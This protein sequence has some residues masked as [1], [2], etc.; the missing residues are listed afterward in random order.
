MQDIQACLSRAPIFSRL[1]EADRN[2]LASI[3]QKRTFEKGEVICWQGETWPMAAYLASGQAEWA[4]LSPD[5][6]R[7]VVF[8]L[9]ACDV[10]WSHSILDDQPMP[11]SLEVKETALVYLWPRETIM[12]FVSRS[13]EAV[14]DVSRVLLR[15]M[16]RVREVVYGFAFHPVAGRLARLL[17]EHYQPVKGQPTPRNLTLDEMAE[18]VG[19]TRELV[20]R[21]LHRFADEGLIQINRMEFVF[22]NPDALEDLASQR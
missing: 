14:W 17:L 19:T 1:S 10:V 7:Q 21:T 3:A 9:Q 5:G 12:P 16:R 20:S 15:Y 2:Q 6:K 4:M 22:K 11:A 8:K 18:T 13:T